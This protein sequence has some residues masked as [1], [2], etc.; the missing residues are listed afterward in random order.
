[1]RKKLL[2][3]AA[4]AIAVATAGAL[5]A[6]CSGT[7]SGGTK[8]EHLIDTE[9]E[10]LYDE[11]GHW[12]RLLCGHDDVID[13]EEHVP[14][15]SEECGGY[16][17]N[18]EV[19]GGDS[20]WQGCALC[21]YAVKHDCAECERFTYIDY[22]TDGHYALPACI[23]E[24]SWAMDTPAV[25]RF[26]AELDKSEPQI[27]AHTYKDDRC[28]AC[29]FSKW[30][31]V[32]EYRVESD[33]DGKYIVIDGVLDSSVTELIIPETIDGLPVKK[34]EA[35][36]KL[37]FVMAESTVKSVTFA[38]LESVVFPA[39]I[40][41]ASDYD[42]SYRINTAERTCK[43]LFAGC[44][45]LKTVEMTGVTCIPD[46]MFNGCKS[47]TEVTVSPDATKIGGSAFS[48]C[49]AL[50]SVTIPETVTEIGN[51]AFRG[52]KLLNNLTLPEKLTA[53]GN[54]TF[55][56]CEALTAVK[57]PAG[58]TE[59]GNAAFYGCKLLQD[60]TLPE[61]LVAM[62]LSIFENCEALTAVEIPAGVTKIG[63]D[64]FRGCKLLKNL[65][66]PEKLTV[67][68]ART[69]YGCEALTAVEI[70]AGITE[71][72]ESVFRAC[73][74]LQTV[75]LPQNLS[76][77]GVEAFGSCL[78]LTALTIPASVTEIG[79]DAFFGVPVSITY[80]GTVDDWCDI[81]ISYAFS[82]ETC[83]L[84]CT[85][86]VFSGEQ[87]INALT[88][89]YSYLSFV[90]LEDGTYEV[91]GVANGMPNSLAI[92]AT[93]RGRAVTR[94]AVNAFK[95]FNSTITSVYT[96]DNVTEIG[97]NAFSG[98][99]KIGFISIGDKT[100]RI[101]R[102]AFNGCKAGGGSGNNLSV[103][104]GKESVLKTI[105]YGAFDET[106]L[107]TLALPDSVSEF[108]GISVG[109]LTE[110]TFSKN[111]TEL[112]QYMFYG[113]RNISVINFHGT[114]EEW[115]AIVKETGWN[116]ADNS[117]TIVLKPRIICTNGTVQIS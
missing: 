2:L 64:A 74:Q 60:V 92:P 50:T 86:G 13:M 21:G 32:Y 56:G 36:N 18:S 7:N 81:N 23:E 105:D 115:N 63:E 29:N 87:T 102:N 68:G 93:Y 41:F 25:Q 67:I 62:S 76:K 77:I 95:N 9:S 59:I 57:I 40:D 111:I 61:K 117:G 38:N 16:F 35:K 48:G 106:T 113:S 97:D 47:L 52:C 80:A 69:F 26:L 66:L 116:H 20:L 71:I 15:F 70:P 104:F 30:K 84:K 46:G 94:I 109:Q 22:G 79:R 89:T 101:G 43:G 1:M 54:H 19:D 4:A 34:W 39:T 42:G 110:I 11:N 112:T 28:T 27:Q 37:E 98:C 100:E 78:A 5:F 45:K 6:G 96:G 103:S 17:L 99:T 83:E 14:Y 90:K 3:I 10:L 108:G 58:V 51:E 44:E 55:N 24:H 88:M 53:I 91:S 33:N 72:G 8:H 49:E 73:K 85:D 114:V 107:K 75:T 65:T 12:H 31:E 82:T